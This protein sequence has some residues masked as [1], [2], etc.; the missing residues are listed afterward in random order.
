M[1]TFLKI[2]PLIIVILLIFLIREGLSIFGYLK[3]CK[4]HVAA[5]RG[6]ADTVLGLLKAGHPVNALDR[7]FGLTPLHYA[8]RNGHTDIARLLI[9][10]GASLTDPSLHGVTPLDWYSEFLTPDQQNELLRV[11]FEKKDK[12]RQPS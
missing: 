3:Y 6:D 12:S 11:A 1:E 5:K 8:V 2:L 4:L 7:R 10:Q 9:Q